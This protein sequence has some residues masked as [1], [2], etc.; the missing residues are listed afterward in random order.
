MEKLV[1]IAFFVLSLASCTSKGSPEEEMAWKK[2]LEANT[3]AALDSFLTAFP[4]S[5]HKKEIAQKRDGIL[6]QNAVAENTVY[7]FKYYL[8]EFPQG[9]H[10]KEIVAKLEN[11]K[12][13]AINFA[14]LEQKT[15]IGSMKYFDRKD[16]ALDI[17][18]IKL[19]AA[20][21]LGNSI[22]Y[23]AS[24]NLTSNL[25][26]DLKAIVQKNDL[27]IKFVENTEDEFLLNFPE[28]RIYTKNK[29]IIIESTDVS[30][31]SYWIIK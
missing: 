9:K 23:K 1:F 13:D 3:I 7:H 12:V 6:Y 22:E 11:L 5:K 8:K 24:I 20:A 10:Q 30:A 19:S 2:T 27:S 26:K 17:L 15:F 21:D 28:G 4:D 29:E 16:A 31:P 14:D 25:K 18:T